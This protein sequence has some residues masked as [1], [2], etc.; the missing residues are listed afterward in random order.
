MT[1]HELAIP[2]YW[3]VINRSYDKWL[4]HACFSEAEWFFRSTMFSGVR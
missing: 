1:A 2:R 4:H 3:A